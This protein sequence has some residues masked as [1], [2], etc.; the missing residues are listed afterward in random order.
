MADMEENSVTTRLL[1][2][3]NVSAVKYGKRKRMYEELSCPTEKLNKRR[4]AFTETIE[5]VSTVTIENQT[6]PDSRKEEA[7][8]EMGEVEGKS[9][10]FSVNRYSNPISRWNIRYVRATLWR[11]PR[12]SIRAIKGIG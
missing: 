3:L 8:G 5:N 10:L 1:T 7:S 4:V 6:V 2:L 9:R 12:P 11:E